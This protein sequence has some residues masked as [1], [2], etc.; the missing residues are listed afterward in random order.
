MKIY[1]IVLLSIFGLI[2]CDRTT[3]VSGK[4]TDIST[5]EPMEGVKVKMQKFNDGDVNDFRTTGSD[6]LYSME[7]DKTKNCKMS[8]FARKVDCLPLDLI[9]FEGGDDH[10]F[11]FQ[12][13]PEDAILEFKVVNTLNHS[14]DFYATLSSDHLSNSRVGELFSK[15]YPVVINAQ[16]SVITQFEF[17]GDDTA[18][19]SYD[20]KDVRNSTTVTKKSFYVA[21]NAK[22]QFEIRY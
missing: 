11:D 14:I 6:G 16:D 2:A 20:L 5:G 3:K 13:R 21:R 4:V 8:I 17:P 9:T 19:L 12:L 1:L 18:N 10:V 15:P 22:E 7:L